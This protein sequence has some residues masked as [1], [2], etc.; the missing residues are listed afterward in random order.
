MLMLLRHFH[1][2]LRYVFA[3]DMMLRAAYDAAVS[4]YDA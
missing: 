3:V 1:Y 4:A 2:L